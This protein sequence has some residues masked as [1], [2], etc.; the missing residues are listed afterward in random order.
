MPLAL[1]FELTG[2]DLWV[3]DLFHDAATGQW[4]GDGTWWAKDLIHEAGRRLIAVTGLAALAIGAASC[5]VG[6]LRN[7]RR[8][9]LFL[10]LSIAAGT[11]VVGIA[12]YGTN[13]DCPDDLLRYGGTQ[14]YVHVFADKPDTAARGECF[15]GGHSSGAFSLTALYFLLRAR[16]SRKASTILFAVLVLGAV[17]SVGQ[18]V[19]GEHFPSHDAWSAII[20]W[21]V[22]LG[23]FAAFRGRVW[24]DVAHLGQRLVPQPVQVH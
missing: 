22:V 6:V 18:W 8:P 13:V 19:R 23:M 14:P 17:F 24:P 7:W 12:K 3:A 11:A 15:P 16:R 2:F 1:V 20:C 5:F 9:A 10:G 4:M 21:Y